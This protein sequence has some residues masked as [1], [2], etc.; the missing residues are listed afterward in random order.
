MPLRRHSSRNRLARLVGVVAVAKR[1]LGGK[2][3]LL[4]PLEQLLAV[5]GDDVDLRVVH[6][7]VDEARHDQVAGPV[8]LDRGA[9]VARDDGRRRPDLDDLAGRDGDRA[10]AVEVDG[11]VRR[12]P[13]RIVAKRQGWPPQD[14]GWR[15]GGSSR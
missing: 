8:G 9:G 11:R 12:D 5:G 13:E 15:L 6:V 10:V 4:Q 14:G 2:G 7:A 1:G 3:I